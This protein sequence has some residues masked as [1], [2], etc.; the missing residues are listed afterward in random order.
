MFVGLVVCKSQI[1]HGLIATLLAFF[2]VSALPFIATTIDP[3]SYFYHFVD[4]IG[5]IHKLQ[6]Q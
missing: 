2:L 5:K 4:R 6:L 3:K 1:L